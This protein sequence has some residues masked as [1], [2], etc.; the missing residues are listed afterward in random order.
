MGFLDDDERQVI[1]RWRTFRDTV[2][3][4][5]L[6]MQSILGEAR[7]QRNPLELEVRLAS[8]AKN[9]TPLHAADVICDAY[10]LG[11]ES[12]VTEVAKY[13][14][15]VPNPPPLARA[16]AEDVLSGS[17]RQVLPRGISHVASPE[18]AG[19]LLGEVRR[20]LRMYPRNS[21]NWIN[22]AL[23]YTV[24]GDINK[25][26]RAVS[27]ALQLS[28][29]NRFVLRS[30]ARFYIHAG[31]C[32][33]AHQI[34]ARSHS[35][36]HDPWV[37]AAEIAVSSSANRRSRNIKY[38]LG[39]AKSD[40]ISSWDASE[41]AG[42]LATIEFWEGSGK[43]AKV[44]FDRSLRNPTENAVAQ[45]FWAVRK[46]LN[47]PAL[48]ATLDTAENV[49]EAR[50]WRFYQEARWRDAANAAW[51]WL[52]DQPFSSRPAALGTF[53]LS[54]ALDS[55][56]E[57]AEMA[58]FALRCN[59]GDFTLLNNYAVSLA[60][61][62]RIPD[63]MRVYSCIR[64]DAL[65]RED[66]AVWLATAGLIH[67]RLGNI[68]QGRNLYELALETARRVGDKNLISVAA[69]FFAREEQRA[70]AGA[71]SPALSE[72]VRLAKKT[73]DPIL[74][75]LSGRLAGD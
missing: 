9:R 61:L 49:W 60:H 38:G 19:R 41:L 47:L 66:R 71:L 23:G 63:A 39:V 33:R 43:R 40:S 69:L 68:E 55:Y 3:S 46:S 58:E 4:G 5:Q 1:P 31:D 18:R 24:L 64:Q 52:R 56:E 11:Q 8:W 57:G 26:K 20:S 44:L 34:L 36:R 75:V 17:T 6:R 30:S 14:C 37:L 65:S 35:V 53:I 74:S 62:G 70:S 73:T 59:P 27:T 28:P 10:V 21:V 22:L 45:A 72:A 54:V 50:A 12:R 13:L 2:E 51:E 42:A 48:N 29:N 7:P 15:A 25:A 67:F 32:E 16:L